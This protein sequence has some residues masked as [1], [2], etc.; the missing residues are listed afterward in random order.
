MEKATL[1]AGC[2]WG[3]E[4]NFSRIKGVTSTKVGYTGGLMA[5]PGYYDVATGTTGHAESI[6]I[7]FD[8]D[9]ISY[10][11]L[12]E[13]FWDI[14]DPTTKNKQGPDI[15]TQYRSAIFYHD[16]KQKK[17]ALSSKKKQEESKRYDSDIKT[18]IVPAS[19][20]YPAEEYHQKYFEKLRSR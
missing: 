3:V 10:E 9:I 4:E 11:E 1:A 14:H 20:F 17:A 18:E 13:V 5:D 15:G 7:I 12:L 6:E 19:I 16:E 2:F 8:P